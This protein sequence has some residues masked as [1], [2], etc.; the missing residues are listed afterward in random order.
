MSKQ[1]SFTSHSREEILQ[2]IASGKKAYFLDTGNDGYDDYL[3]LGDGDALEDL[4]QEIAYWMNDWQEEEMT[5]EELGCVLML[6]DWE[7]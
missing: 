4:Q 2:A 6:V 1:H 5:L 7:I 3:I